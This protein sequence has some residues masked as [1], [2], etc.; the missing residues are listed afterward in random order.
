R[1]T[2][3]SRNHRLSV[4]GQLPE[5]FGDP[6]DVGEHDSGVAD[7]VASETGTHRVHR[8]V[9]SPAGRTGNRPRPVPFVGETQGQ[10]ELEGA[11]VNQVGDRDRQQRY[12]VLL[13]VIGESGGGQLTRQLG[14]G[15][16]G[17]DGG[18]QGD[19]AGD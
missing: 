5:L 7:R 17:G 19:R 14:E 4:L 2:A 9:Q 12:L 3:N 6:S 13:G 1:T 18:G 10:L 11:F 15:Q 16:R 8:S